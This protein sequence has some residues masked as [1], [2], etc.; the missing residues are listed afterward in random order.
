MNPR[1]IP[2]LVVT[3]LGL[4]ALVSADVLA[5]APKPA[6]KPSAKAPNAKKATPAPTHTTIASI[7]AD[8]ITV[9]EPKGTRTYKIGKDTEFNLRGQKVKIEEIKTGMRVSVTVGSDPAV[10]QRISASDAP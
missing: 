6:P 5:A 8:S 9:D 3:V 10:A 7:S 2:V 4:L 1:N